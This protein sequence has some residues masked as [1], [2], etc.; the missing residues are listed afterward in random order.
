MNTELA[1]ELIADDRLAEMGLEQAD[2][3]HAL[4]EGIRYAASLTRHD[5]RAAKGIGIWNAINRGLG[6]ALSPKG[7]TRTERN[8][9]ALTVHPRGS[10][11]IAV[12][13]GDKGTG[14]I[15]GPQPRNSYPLT[16][17]LHMSQAITRNRLVVHHKAHFSRIDRLWGPPP[18]TYF[19]LH[20]IEDVNAGLIKGELSLAVGRSEDSITEWDERIILSPPNDDVA[21]TAQE[22]GQDPP[23]D[24]PVIDRSA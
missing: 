7:W 19:L 14:T 16:N 15:V 17:K 11:V 9:W 23:I 24:V 6:D 2:L 18:L 8:N 12:L 4:H 3:W 1:Y 22:S 20:H 10:L 21:Q 13:A 5:T